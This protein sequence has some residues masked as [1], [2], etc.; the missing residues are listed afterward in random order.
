MGGLEEQGL[1]GEGSWVGELGKAG[2]RE[3]G[4]WSREQGGMRREE[5]AGSREQGGGSMEEGEEAGFTV[6][7]TPSP[8]PSG[9]TGCRELSSVWE[10]TVWE[11]RAR[12]AQSLGA[13]SLV[14]PRLRSS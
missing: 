12:E 11:L 7:I 13:Q 3:Y 14:G 9:I 5:G 10:P 2:I 1:E 6:T 8:S 4:V